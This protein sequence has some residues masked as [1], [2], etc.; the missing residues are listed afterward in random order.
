VAEFLQLCFEN[1][2]NHLGT[3][4][5]KAKK[6]QKDNVSILD[7]IDPFTDVVTKV[8]WKYIKDTK[9]E[10][11]S[12]QDKAESQIEEIYE[13]VKYFKSKLNSFD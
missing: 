12:V 1:H 3:K 2:D 13:N 9:K 10:E 6:G 7:L 4:S 5:K 8:L 11:E